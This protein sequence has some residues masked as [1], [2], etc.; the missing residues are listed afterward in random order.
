MQR[1]L[2]QEAET[3]N[4][5]NH[6]RK[7]WHRI[8]RAMGCVVVF[9]TT[10]A[11]ILPAI[12]MEKA[13]LCGMEEHTHGQGCY[14][15]VKEQTTEVLTCP[16]ETHVH[17]SECGENCGRADFAVHVHGD[18]CLDENGSLIC[19][20][21]E[22]EAH[23][24]TDACWTIKETVQETEPAEM[25]EVTEATEAAEV[26]DPTEAAEE[27]Q[28]AELVKTL[29]CKE[30]EIILH[31]H[32]EEC[33]E[34]LS[35]E[36][37]G[38]YQVL[39]CAMLEVVEHIHTE[40][41]MGKQTIP[42][43]TETMTCGLEES[44]DHAHGDLCYGTWELICGMEAHTHSLAC[45]SDSTA[46]TETAEIWEATLPELSGY[47]A[48]DMVAIARS[49]LGY[50]ESTENYNVLDDGETM[51]GYTRYGAWYGEPYSD[52]NAMFASFCLHYAGVDFLPGASDCAAWVE[53]L[54]SEDWDM[55]YPA[56]DSDPLPG[57][58]VFFDDDGDGRADRTGVVAEVTAETDTDEAKLT[59]IEG[60]CDDTVQSMRYEQTNPT[61]L[62]YVMLPTQKEEEPETFALTA[63][64]ESGIIVTISGD[65][66]SLPYPVEE[67]T[68][69]ATDIF[70]EEA[71]T[72]R[73]EALEAEGVE[74]AQNYLLDVTLWHGEEMIEP[75]GS[76]TVAF[77]GMPELEGNSTK[78]YHIDEETSTATDMDAVLD[79]DG[80][81][82]L[83]TDHFSTYSISLYS[84]SWNEINADDSS[85]YLGTVTSGGYYYLN[86]NVS[87]NSQINITKDTTIDLNGK[88]INFGN[89]NSTFGHFSVSNGAT[90][91]IVDDSL[92]VKPQ[93]QSEI[94]IPYGEFTG[95]NYG[96]LATMAGTT[97]TYY[98]TESAKNTDGISTT[99]TIVEYEADLSSLGAI[100]GSGG[101]YAIY[102]N[103]GNL[104][105]CGGRITNNGGKHAICVQTN[106][107]AANKGQ[108]TVNIEGGFICGTT[109]GNL[110]G[111]VFFGGGTLNISGGVIAANK[112][113]SGGGVYF[114]HGYLNVSSNAVI[115]GNLAYYVGGGIYAYNAYPFNMTG[116]YITN[117]KV[118][119]GDENQ[120]INGGGGVYFRYNRFNMQSGY[121]TGNYAERAGGGIFVGRNW[122]DEKPAAT[123]EMTG[124]TVASNYAATGEGGGIR[125]TG[126]STGGI[127][128]SAD[129]PLYITNNATATI[130]DWGGGGIFVQEYATLN[131][132]N[133][134][135]T[136][137]NA[138]GYGGGV[139]A[140]PTGNTLLLHTEGAAIYNN[141]AS[142][143]SASGGGDNKTYDFNLAKPYFDSISGYDKYKDY[144]CVRNDENANSAISLVTGEMIGGGAANW[145][146]SSDKKLITISKT[147]NATANYLFA[148]NSNPT[149][150]AID[151]A[152]NVAGVIISGNY[153][154]VHGGGIMTNGGLIIGRTDNVVTAAPALEI[155]GT[156]E[157]L[158]DNVFQNS[159]RA[160]EFQL[161]DSNG[162]VVGTAT[163]DDGNG[164]FTIS[165]NAQ[166]TEADIYTYYLTEVNGGASG[167]MY[168]DT[169]YEIVVTID[170]KEV[171]LVGIKFQSYSV[172]SVKVNKI[173]TEE[174]EEITVPSNHVT[175]YFRNEDNWSAVA[176]HA[177][178]DS[179]DESTG[180]DIDAY[181]NGW[182]GG[183]VTNIVRGNWYMVSLPITSDSA[184][185]N[186]I[187]NNNDNGGQTSDLRVEDLIDGDQVW[188][189]K[190]GDTYKV[191]K[192]QPSDWDSVK[193]VTTS[194]TDF[195]SIQNPDESFTLTLN[196]TAFTNTKTTPQDVY[197]RLTKT[198]ALNDTVKL[199]GAQFSLVQQNDE[200]DTLT[201]TSDGSG[202]VTFGPLTR[203]AT[204]I[205]TETKAPDGY[206]L[207]ADPWT[208]AVDE[209]GVVTIKNG[210]NETVQTTQDGN[211]TTSITYTATITNQGGY[212]LPNTGGA[213]TYLY[214]LGGIVL[215]AVPLVYGYSQWRR[216]ERRAAR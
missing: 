180:V 5:R 177:W 184:Y 29:T 98:V 72:I 68:V 51:R 109:G 167:V 203:G 26:T 200:T 79:S 156:K 170:K 151:A 181:D 74:A 89:D 48:Q 64:T 52:W 93:K 6:R 154:A 185:L 95:S 208:V 80:Q 152:K 211:I 101:D 174:P 61:I 55:F 172:K 92:T 60:D 40:A 8:V 165:P 214:T 209:N 204:Y 171:T 65:P 9:C 173:V 27:T 190:E 87:W 59:A 83:D 17:N 70:S 213:G 41:C 34:T 131:I 116:G 157:L 58:L 155:T 16:F 76:V 159:G 153:S 38:E 216:R 144:F 21:P 148:L 42:V 2:L 57:D 13:N 3:Y 30:P 128:G 66:E 49:Q 106:D 164:K 175:L 122:G 126:Y 215:T 119:Y 73:D 32:N 141:E 138:G 100:V 168:D 10:Y 149:D 192:Q 107:Q 202:Q 31:T 44:E 67:I 99:E 201:G 47:W 81:V 125:I 112:A 188:V 133:A 163:S 56:A 142:G 45:G 143:S 46:D 145:S 75:T 111:G 94:P 11:L 169:K 147:G 104:N 182:P 132:Q 158:I 7:I 96:K 90:L 22:V 15:Q 43:D 178:K 86:S 183:K 37:D 115:T 1:K 199:P 134:I 191:I 140:C 69:T 124:G 23:A 88:K 28:P 35:N 103:N 102:C 146:G 85:K 189:Y 33:Y 4:K 127:S 186:F 129:S 12:T 176:L 193:T 150:S 207:P 63:Q 39:K 161:T 20:L 197:L 114:E 195:T 194:F 71:S 14:A 166:Y 210:A 19:I 205:L 118:Q 117:N 110:G 139:G 187:F 84:T 82:V 113:N 62:G 162:T 53:T 196:G 77:S 105:I 50:S 91:T 206:M 179:G 78:V 160:F 108:Q 121:I 97:L 137:N 123:F 25:P 136:D 24:H 198:D 212:E 36:E 120:N 54:S 18:L 130:F 135:I